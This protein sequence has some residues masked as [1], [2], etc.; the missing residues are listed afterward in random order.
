MRLLATAALC[1]GCG[2][3]SSTALATTICNG[4]QCSGVC[5]KYPDGHEYC[6]NNLV[7]SQD[8]SAMSPRQDLQITITNAGPDTLQRLK[9]LLNK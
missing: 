7:A 6:S 8:D 3:I 9:D 5:I 2:V 4:A 1:F